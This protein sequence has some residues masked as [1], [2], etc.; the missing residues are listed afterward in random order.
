M[1]KIALVIMFGLTILCAGVSAEEQAP[2]PKDWKLVWRDEFNGRKLNAKKWN[3]L[4]REHSKHNEL[5]YYL[6]DE[7]FLQDGCLRLRSRVRDYGP[8]HYTSGRVDTR[9]KLAPVYGRFEIRARLP[10]GKGIWP[11]HWLYPQDRDWPMERLMADAVANGKER[12]IPEHRPWYTEIDIMEFL[13]H[14]PNIVYGTLH[15]HTFDGQKKTSSVT[16]KGDCDY[17]RDFH[18]YALEWEPDAIRWFIDRQLIHTTTN[19]IPHTPHYLILNTA[20][21]GQWP[22]NPDSST[23]FPQFHDIDYVRVYQR[24]GYFGR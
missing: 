7:A 8:M 23:T 9:G 18:V 1:S 14:E 11:A 6:P 22:G 21:G 17:S 4:L 13:G 19:G 3:I 15:Y 2:A 5:Q 24:A 16:W 12:I 10:V 20:V